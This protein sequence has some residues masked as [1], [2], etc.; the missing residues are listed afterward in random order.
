M[1]KQIQNKY[2]ISFELYYDEITYNDYNYFFNVLTRYHDKNGYIITSMLTY[3]VSQ[4]IITNIIN[5]FNTPTNVGLIYYDKKYYYALEY[6][7]SIK[8]K[9]PST[10]HASKHLSGIIY[11]FYYDSL[12]EAKNDFYYRISKMKNALEKNKCNNNISSIMDL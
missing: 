1:D 8:T 4:H 10:L 11:D 3:N 12:T 7:C 6:M 9:Y 5:I 2:E